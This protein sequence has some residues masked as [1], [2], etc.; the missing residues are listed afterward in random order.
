M[1][2]LLTA[3]EV[4][5]LGSLFQKRNGAG[6]G[7]RAAKNPLAGSVATPHDDVGLDKIT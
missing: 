2:A 6:T 3:R 5:P 4:R 1:T 7:S